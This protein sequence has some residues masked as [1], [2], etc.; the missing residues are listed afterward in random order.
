[1]FYHG[2]PI[3]PAGLLYMIGQA[4]KLS[5]VRSQQFPAATPP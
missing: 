1:M 2:K 3:E 5:P 4:R